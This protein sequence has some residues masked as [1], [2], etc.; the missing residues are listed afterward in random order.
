MEHDSSYNKR[1]RKQIIAR[2][3]MNKKIKTL[4]ADIN[5]NGEKTNEISQEIKRKKT[6][7][8]RRQTDGKYRELSLRLNELHI[9][10]PIIKIE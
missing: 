8:R 2:V 1:S 4:E 3:V 7:R 10:Q 5:K 6:I 9:S